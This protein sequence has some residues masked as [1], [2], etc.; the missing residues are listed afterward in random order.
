MASTDDDCVE[1]GS[2]REAA[3]NQ[4][5]GAA[6]RG[7]PDDV[8]D[9]RA[10]RASPT[11][12]GD[13]CAG[14][15][16]AL[17]AGS[18]KCAGASSG[19]CDARR[20]AA[21][22]AAAGERAGPYIANVA[23]TRTPHQAERMITL[24]VFYPNER[25]ERTE[26]CRHVAA[27]DILLRGGKP[28][29]PVR[30]RAWL[31]G[32]G[33]ERR[34]ELVRD[35]IVRYLG[36]FVGVIPDVDVFVRVARNAQ[37]EFL[38]LAHDESV[39]SKPMIPYLVVWKDDDVETVMDGELVE[40][41]DAAAAGE[42]FW[43][44]KKKDPRVGEIESPRALR[45]AGT[46]PPA[47]TIGYELFAGTGEIAVKMAEIF[48]SLRCVYAFEIA[49]CVVCDAARRHPR[50]A[51]V[52]CD[53]RKMRYLNI[54]RGALVWC[55]PPCT[56]YSP[57]K[58]S[59]YSRMGPKFKELSLFDADT[60]VATCLDFVRA[61]RSTNWVIENPLG[62]LRNRSHIWSGIHHVRFTTSYCKYGF[63]YRKWTDLFVS[64]AVGEALRAAGG[65]RPKCTPVASPCPHIRSGKHPERASGRPA[66]ELARVPMALVGRI[67]RAGVATAC[68]VAYG[69]TR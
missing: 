62:E 57:Q 45:S 43:S 52:T 13:F 49:G 58:R 1:K 11:L 3:A 66:R 17:E 15:A 30:C 29:A 22:R 67:L 5:T 33:Y 65:L 51:V 68:G 38:V 7:W 56:K 36:P 26:R 27:C 44:R 61:S 41:L 64:P 39:R 59:H 60:Y 50:V 69:S 10:T 53:V 42:S 31:R 6:R 28:R 2:E 55:S 14:C 9:E 8:V 12:F 19:A 40:R 54:P 46:L 21:R 4:S 16:C 20:A 47:P 63:K 37:T 25:S 34:F 48:P 18:G 23:L 32:V 35:A 24:R